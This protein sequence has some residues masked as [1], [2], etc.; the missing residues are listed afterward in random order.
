MTLCK[1]LAA[2]PLTIP[3]VTGTSD[4]YDSLAVLVDSGYPKTDDTSYPPGDPLNDPSVIQPDDWY[5]PLDDVFMWCNNGA[6]LL[7][8]QGGYHWLAD[9]TKLCP[10]SEDTGE[11]GW[12]QETWETWG[13]VGE[14]HAPVEIPVGSGNWYRSMLEGVQG[15]PL[16]CS[17][18]Y[19]YLQNPL[20]NLTGIQEIISVW[21]FQQIQAAAGP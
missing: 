14:S 20:T 4:T 17:K 21:E 18:W 16:P 11:P 13:V 3:P 19:A 2:Y 8:Y 12:E 5:L 6:E 1:L 9:P 15:T 7:M 10:Y